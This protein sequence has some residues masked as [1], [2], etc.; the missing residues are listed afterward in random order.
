MIW[1]GLALWHN[2]RCWLF[3]AKS[4]SSIYT[5]YMI[6]KHILS[7]NTE[8]DQTFLFLTIQSSIIH[9]FALSLNV[10]QFYST[11]R[12]GET[13]LDQSGSGSD[14]NERELRIPQSFGIT[15]TSTSD[16]L[17]SYRDHSLR[18][19][20]PSAEVQ[21]VYSTAPANWAN[22]IRLVTQIWDKIY[23]LMK[24]ESI[25]LFWPEVIYCFK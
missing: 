14:G 18:E 2:N 15:G 9:L 4:C 13:T 17:V 12:V 6:C 24:D 8:N 22:G 16:Y 3:K 5:K 19:S 23:Y 11:Y 21:S 10:K 1:F 7:I 25:L 20:Y